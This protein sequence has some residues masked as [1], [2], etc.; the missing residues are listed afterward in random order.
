[1]VFPG[2]WPAKFIVRHVVTK[3]AAYVSKDPRAAVEEIYTILDLVDHGNSRLF[4][5]ALLMQNSLLK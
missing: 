5:V 4:I 1:M 2:M 3:V